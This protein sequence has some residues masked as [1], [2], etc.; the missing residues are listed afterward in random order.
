MENKHTLSPWEVSKKFPTHVYKWVSSGNAFRIVATCDSHEKDE[1]AIA[2]AR[3][4]AAAP[5]LLEALEPFSELVG[6]SPLQLN[7]MMRKAK[8][9][10]A[11][12]RG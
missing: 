8:A 1:Q 3:L 11:K 5:E 4:I 9:A 7:E 6:R 2:D 12:A 10:I